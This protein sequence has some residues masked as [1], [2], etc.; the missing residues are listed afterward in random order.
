MSNKCS[1]RIFYC[2]MIN[3]PGYAAMI[4][5]SLH[6]GA[7]SNKMIAVVRAMRDAGLKRA[8]FPY[9]F[10]DGMLALHMYL[11]S[12]CRTEAVLQIFLPVVANP[13]FRKIYALF[14]FAWFC[15][16][17]VVNSD[18]VILYNH[19]IE[20]LLGSLILVIKGNRPILDIEDAAREDEQG[21]RGFI[22]RPL[23]YLFRQLTCERKLIVSEALAKILDLRQY[24]VV[25]G[26]AR[27]EAVADE[28][29]YRSPW[30]VG[31]TGEPLMIHYGGSLTADTGVDLFCGAV[32]RLIGSLRR[33]VCQVHFV[34]T[35]FG[36]EAKISALQRQC[37]D[38]GVRI[39]F[40][41]D[42]SPEEYLDQFR[43]CHAA[44][45]LK[46]PESQMTIPPFLPR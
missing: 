41:P 9:R 43:R 31:E 8:W 37:A 33:D 35:G 19:A 44:L 21:W 5:E 15:A 12:F 10:L 1:L 17:H 29:L 6:I 4:G 30:G 39:S 14:G 42:S 7:A 40:H 11:L 16:A 13:Y 46:L 27:W 3:T 18:R 36:S 26:V 45:S 24:C 22:G 28:S 32:G 34:V 2:G 23:F 20:Y 38:S 25:Y